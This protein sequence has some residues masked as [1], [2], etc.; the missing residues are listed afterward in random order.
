MTDTKNKTSMKT[1]GIVAIAAILG[2]SLVAV[3]FATQAEAGDNAIAAKKAGM[4]M[5]NPVP[6]PTL[7]TNGETGG[8]PIVAEIASFE[9]KSNDKGDWIVDSTIECA[10]A[11]NAVTKGKKN[12]SG[13]T[14]GAFAGAKVWFTLD[15]KPV[16]IKTGET[17]N[18]IPGTDFSK[19]PSN[20]TWNLCEQVFEMDSNFN[21][22]IINCEQAWDIYGDSTNQAVLDALVA[23]CPDNQVAGEPDDPFKLV[24]ECDISLLDG[25]DACAQSLEV[26]TKVAG[27]HPAMI[28]L[29]DV[30]G[31]GEIHTVQAWAAL[32][33][34][35]SVGSTLTFTNSTAFDSES[36]SFGS[37]GVIIGKR[38]FVAEPI[39][40]QTI[41]SG[42]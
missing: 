13:E 35:T 11:V 37:A 34:G 2:F 24:F 8:I 9:I 12:N 39:Q 23:A 17:S 20:S 15:G 33:A 5:T 25:D 41:S 27:T 21:D 22:L 40:M 26:F 31:Q 3:N 7:Q 28:M 18:V 42:P 10:T 1:V 14:E 16:A 29:K 6:A 38:M 19:V 30:T 36:S 4:S 32:N